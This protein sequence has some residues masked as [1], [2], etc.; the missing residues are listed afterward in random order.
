MDDEESPQ[1]ELIALIKKITE[2]RNEKNRLGQ[3]K[4]KYQG[5]LGELTDQLRAGGRV[6]DGR[7]QGV[8]LRQRQLKSKVLELEP[9]T[10]AVKLEIQKLANRETE[11]R[12]KIFGSLD[13]NFSTPGET[14]T[15]RIQALRRKYNEFSSDSTRIS[16]MRLMASQFAEELDKALS[17]GES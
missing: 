6:S 12:L 14:L 9:K 4:L 2:L 13:K 7:F 3:I 5:Q 10:A 16:S 1:S 11:L 17:P 15:A 8:V